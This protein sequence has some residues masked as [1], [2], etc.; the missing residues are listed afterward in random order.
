MKKFT[1]VLSIVMILCLCGCNASVFKGKPTFLTK[2][3]PR[4]LS[5]S[6]S[7]SDKTVYSVNIEDAQFSYSDEGLHRSKLTITVYGTVTYVES[8]YLNYSGI[9][10][11]AYKICDSEG[12]IVE[13]GVF[14]LDEY[15]VGDRFKEEFDCYFEAEPGETY[16]IEFIEKN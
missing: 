11:F 13:K 8:S 12:Y 6:R 3:L 14:S 5:C 4:E 10:Q 2:D 9:N 16:T 7:F 1:L 15:A